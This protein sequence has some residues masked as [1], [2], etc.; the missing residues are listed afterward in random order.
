M[1]P[2]IDEDPRVHQNPQMGTKFGP[3]P[4][5][6]FPN[7]GGIGFSDSIAGNNYGGPLLGYQHDAHKAFAQAHHLHS[8]P[9]SSTSQATLPL[10][11]SPQY[12]SWNYSQGYPSH[13]R[14]QGSAHPV[15]HSWSAPS[16][17]HPSPPA[18]NHYGGPTTTT[19]G[20]G[21]AHQPLGVDPNLP[22]TPIM[23]PPRGSERVS[24]HSHLGPDQQVLHWDYPQYPHE[25]SPQTSSDQP[26]QNAI[27]STNHMPV[28]ENDF[29]ANSHSQQQAFSSL[30]LDAPIDDGLDPHFTH[31]KQQE[32]HGQY[33]PSP[34]P[35]NSAI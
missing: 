29:I 8:P 24:S 27:L 14:P 33:P 21:H 23:T 35:S 2:P 25:A 10:A 7:N 34:S 28:Q 15:H 22:L 18:P 4:Y 32:Q 11:Q 17:Y 9:Q 20:Q 16:G 31:N 26:F 6:G 30:D 19:L 5:S 12:V 13:G 1:V 3:R